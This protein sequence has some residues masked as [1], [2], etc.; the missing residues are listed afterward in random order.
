MELDLNE[1]L[2]IV[3][4]VMLSQQGRE[5]N[6]AETVLFKGSWQGLTYDKI[7]E[8]SFYTANYFKG[9]V[10]HNFWKNLSKALGEDVNKRNFKG[11]IARAKENFNIKHDNQETE[12]GLGYPYVEHGKIEAMA[13]QEILKPGSL[14]RIKAPPRMGKTTFLSRL[15]RY[16][17]TQGYRGI[18]LSMSLAGKEDFENLDNFLKWFCLNVAQI[19]NLDEECLKKNFEEDNWEKKL[20]NSKLKATQFFE[21]YML[22]EP[23]KPFILGL[24]RLD[25]LFAYQEIADGFL[26]LLRNWHTTAK[27][28]ETWGKLRLIL[29]YVEDYTQLDIYQSPFNVGIPIELEDLNQEQIK[30]L[31]QQYELELNEEQINKIMDM[32]GGN[33]HLLK[34]MF[35]NLSMKIE[36]LDELID[37]APTYSGIYEDFLRQKFVIFSKSKKDEKENKQSEKLKREFNKVIQSSENNLGKTDCEEINKLYDLGFIIPNNNYFRVKYKLYS[38][39]FKNYLCD[40]KG[41]EE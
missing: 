20:G 41:E 40:K 8:N 30:Q 31:A 12:V 38:L 17:K 32:I 18:N 23:S 4:Q 9:D 11:A 14:L 7:A 29:C 35:L 2:S 24:D 26:G 3:N 16:G 22:T 25:K 6:D 36:T 37:K 10:G 28:N 1:A 33:P 34:L 39:Y 27:I 15:I 5:L 19:L 21:D 13:K